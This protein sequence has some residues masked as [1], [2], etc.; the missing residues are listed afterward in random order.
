[1]CLLMGLEVSIHFIGQFYHMIA[2]LALFLRTFAVRVL[3]F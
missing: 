3:T 1:M 2:V